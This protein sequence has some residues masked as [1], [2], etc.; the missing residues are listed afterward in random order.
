MRQLAAVMQRPWLFSFF[1]FR[2]PQPHAVR[3]L[4]NHTPWF[5]W[6]PYLWTSADTPRSD[7]LI[8]CN[9]QASPSP[10]NGFRD[11]RYGDLTDELDLWGD[12]THPSSQGQSKVANLL[13]QFITGGLPTS[14]KHIS[15]WVTPWI[16]KQ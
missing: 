7:G 13:V 8:W 10:R 11:V 15:D 5:D 12:Y 1:P 9:N 14:Q 4:A 3:C 6:G 16:K 2:E